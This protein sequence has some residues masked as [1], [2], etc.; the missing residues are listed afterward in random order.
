MMRAYPYA[1][2][3]DQD[4]EDSGVL[5][6][7]ILRTNGFFAA[8]F[9]RVFQ[10]DGADGEEAEERIVLDSNKRKKSPEDADA[11]LKDINA[12]QETMTANAK[13]NSKKKEAKARQKARVK[14]EK[15][16]Q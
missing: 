2:L 14:A 10:E 12:E 13:R 1:N 15:G 16:D 5:G 11:G 6:T 3:E 4:T 8:C 9:V 7:H